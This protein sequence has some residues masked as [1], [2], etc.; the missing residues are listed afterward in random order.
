MPECPAAQR[1]AAVRAASPAREAFATEPARS[2]ALHCPFADA[3]CRQASRAGR[4]RLCSAAACPAGASLCSS[5]ASSSVLSF[6]IQLT[7]T[8]SL[9]SRRH[10]P[11][12]EQAGLRPGLQT[13][14]A[15]GHRASG[16]QSSI[17]KPACKLQASQQAPGG[18][19]RL[20]SCGFLQVQWP[21]EARKSRNALS[22]VTNNG[23]GAELPSKVRRIR[24][25]VV[26]TLTP[27]SQAEM[28]PNLP[29][30]APHAPRHSQ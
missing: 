27:H 5:R 3:V 19:C 29:A 12:P 20:D 15:P 28:G 4:A 25:D 24:A 14:E 9:S 2:C 26:R 17:S 1:A 23:A 13:H 22:D 6:I 30:G 11:G 21:Q 7:G 8:P 16:E 10:G 18:S